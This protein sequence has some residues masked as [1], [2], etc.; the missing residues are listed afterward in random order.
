MNHTNVVKASEVC[1]VKV[2]NTADEDLGE[3]NEIVIDKTTGKVGYVV[4]D[5]GGILGF[6]NKYFALPWKIFSYDADEDCF[7]INLDKERLKNA[8]GF[9]KDAWPDFSETAFTSNIN[10]YYSNL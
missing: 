8:P 7:V 1:G 10:R 3:I 2:R 4:L 6:G 9:D 5:F